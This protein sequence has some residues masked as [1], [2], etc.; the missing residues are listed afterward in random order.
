MSH[1]INS[2][3]VYSHAIPARPNGEMTTRGIV[4]FISNKG[5]NKYDPVKIKDVKFTNPNGV[6]FGEFRQ[7]ISVDTLR[8]IADGINQI[9]N[10]AEAAMK[11]MTELNNK[12]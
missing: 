2:C 7:E 4:D 10:D 6:I 3:I 9:C 8:A 5:H 1:T 12:A 11:R